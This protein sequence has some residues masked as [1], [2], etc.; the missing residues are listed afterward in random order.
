MVERYFLVEHNL[1]NDFPVHQRFSLFK[2]TEKGKLT[3]ISGNSRITEFLEIKKDELVISE[4]AVCNYT[5]H[6]LEKS[7]ADLWGATLQRPL[8]LSIK[9]RRPHSYRKLH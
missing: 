8:W 3:Y 2:V 7:A 9:E 5:H 1:H 4:M 6:R